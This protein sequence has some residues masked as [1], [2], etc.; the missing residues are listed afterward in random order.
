PL[1]R[2]NHNEFLDRY[3]PGLDATVWIVGSTK[4]TMSFKNDTAYPILITRTVR[5]DGNRRWLTCKMR[6][7][8]NRRKPTVTNTVIQPGE[9]A[10]DTTVRD[11]SKPAGYYY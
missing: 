7:V 5:N 11:S 2:N 9:R 6:S 10:V 4:Q 3:P 1:A 8:P